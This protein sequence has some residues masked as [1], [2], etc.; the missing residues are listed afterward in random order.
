M[1]A[2]GA[3]PGSHYPPWLPTDLLSDFQYKNRRLGVYLLFIKEKPLSFANDR[4]FYSIS[5]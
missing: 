5:D 4:G 2:L 3:S 1:D